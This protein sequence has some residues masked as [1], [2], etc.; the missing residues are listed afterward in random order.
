VRSGAVIVG[1]DDDA[2][3]R[4]AVA[5]G[6]RL[7]EL[8]E[9]PLDVITVSSSS[10]AEALRDAAAGEDGAFVVLG[11]THRRSI[12]RTLRGTARRLLAGAP[13]PVAV[14]P[15]GFADRPEAPLQRS[16]VVLPLA[17]LAYDDFGDVT[18]YLE[19]EYRVDLLVCGTRRRSPL[20]PVVLGSVT[21]RLLHS[22]RCPL[23]IVP[24][25][26]NYRSTHGSHRV[27]SA[28]GP[29]VTPRRR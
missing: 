24:R 14:A 1:I 20:P 10:P 12:A 29:N 27:R 15:V 23:L 3:A 25:S 9:A 13:C 8:L 26:A 4:D 18:P 16:G 2:S 28:T 6:N 19:N 11:P 21:E 22:A 5:L 7:A 17:P